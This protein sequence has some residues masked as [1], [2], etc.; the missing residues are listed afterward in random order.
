MTFLR[1]LPVL[2]LAACATRSAIETSQNYARLGDYTRAFQVLDELYR[3]QTA[4]GGQP[5]GEL[6]EAHRDAKLAFLYDRAMARIFQERENAALA[7]LAELTSLAPDYPGLQSMVARAKHKK[8]VRLVSKGD[9]ALVRKEFAAA[10]T[11]YI[12]AQ[13]VEAD[14]V[15]AAEGIENVRKATG[16]L[17]TRAQEQFLEAVRKL[18]E[19]R[20]IEVQWHAGNA[21]HNAP[22][23]REGKELQSR[24]RHENALKALARGKDCEQ[25][26]K[27]GAAFQEYKAARDLD[28]TLPGIDAAIEQMNR[29]L[30]AMTLADQAQKA[31]RTGDF[32][33]A[34]EFLGKAFDLSVMARNDIGELVAQVKKLEGEGRYQA[35]RDLETLGKKVD[36]LAAFE[37]LAKDWPAGLSDEKARIDGLKVDID[38][39]AKEW[40]DAE[41]AEAAGDLAK[42]LEHYQASER[43]YAGWKDGKDRIAKLRAALARQNG[44]PGGSGG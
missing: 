20:F 35:A 2:L 39:A 37:A 22:D 23:H 9:D 29:E 8:A 38:G 30:Q 42:A 32:D 17:T 26:G 24:A 3:E 41:A 36:A 28:R 21:V 34:R 11:W 5:D 43:F 44:T 7:D 33:L 10:M 18:P 40:A 14:L 31:M 13:R 27:F 15:A 4:D 19:F 6:M 16:R 1:L 12:E 25:H